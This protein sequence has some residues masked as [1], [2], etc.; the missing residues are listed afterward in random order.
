[1]NAPFDRRKSVTGLSAAMREVRIRLARNDIYTAIGPVSRHSEAVL[2]CI[3][4]EDDEG[5]EH[6][7]LRVI[8]D[9]RKA[10]EKRRELRSL[11][12][13]APSIVSPDK[14]AS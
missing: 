4:L 12:A 2:L 13:S 11:L 6:H 5:L 3:E 7:L 14:A 1:M 8:T 9:V 10:A